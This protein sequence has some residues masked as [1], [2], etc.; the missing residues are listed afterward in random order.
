MKFV[1]LSLVCGGA[2]ALVHSQSSASRTALNAAG[3]LDGFY[4]G[5]QAGDPMPGDGPWDPMGFSQIHGMVQGSEHAGVMPSPQWLREAEIKHGRVAML[6]FTGALVQ[7]YGMHFPGSLNGEYYEAGVNPFEA[8]PS[9]FAT[10][11]TGMLSLSWNMSATTSPADHSVLP[12]L[13][14][15]RSPTPK[16]SVLLMVERG[17]VIFSGAS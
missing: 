11:P 15:T 2:H 6:A 17:K 5:V 3:P 4:G 12:V 14:S 1:A 8:T 13:H 16:R 9:A 10:C 7:S